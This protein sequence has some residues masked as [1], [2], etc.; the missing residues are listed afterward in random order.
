MVG[1]QRGPARGNQPYGKLMPPRL[2][3]RSGRSL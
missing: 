3:A 1:R 2:S